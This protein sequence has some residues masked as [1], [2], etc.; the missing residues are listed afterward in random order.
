MKYFLF[1]FCFFF[2]NI[3]TAQ[4]SVHTGFTAGKSSHTFTV[5][6]QG[7][8]L[9]PGIGE[10]I[11]YGVPLIV[12]KGKWS[13]Q[14]GIFSNDL[15]RAFYF[16]TPDGSQYGSK[17]D[18]ASS[19]STFKIPFIISKEFKLVNRVSLA[20]KAGIAWLTNRTKSDNTE[21][22]SGT[23][24][25]PDFVVVERVSSVVN[26][27]KFTAE[28]GLD[29]NIYPFRHFI[30]T[31]GITYSYGLK[32]IENTDITYRLD[33]EEATETLVSRGSGLNIHFGLRIPIH[34]LHGGHHRDLFK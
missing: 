25:E 21:V 20:P 29:L 6:G 31:A 26:K 16:E 28:A 33:G 8:V 7:D 23:I 18:D 10:E 5:E 11:T 13:F 30:L 19:I 1:I 4:L 24:N 12:A 34:I 14:T 9:Q 32:S 27:N 17:H 22:Q 2:T 15:T 3:A